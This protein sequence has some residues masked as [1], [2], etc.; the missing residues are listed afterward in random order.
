[1]PNLKRGRRTRELPHSRQW[2]QRCTETRQFG[3]VLIKLYVSWIGIAPLLAPLLALLLGRTHSLHKGNL[4]LDHKEFDES[5]QSL[6][7]PPPP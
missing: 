6:S 4:H 1:M 3:P 2:L 5:N 7:F